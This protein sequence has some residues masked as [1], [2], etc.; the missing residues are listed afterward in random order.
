M[1]ST[2]TLCTWVGVLLATASVTLPAAATPTAPLVLQLP[3]PTGAYPIAVTELHLTDTARADP[4]LSDQPRELMVRLWYPTVDDTADPPTPWMAAGAR[5]EETVYLTN[6]GV[7]PNTWTLGPSHSHTDAPARVDD[8]PFP[9]VLFSP[10]MDDAA[11]WNTAQAEDLASH[12]YVVVDINHTHESFAVQFPDGHTEHTR[13]PLT[14]DTRIMTDELLPPRVADT[15]FVLNALTLLSTHQPITPP[16]DV[17]AG[18]ADI[19]DISRIGMYGHSLGGATTAAAMHDDDRIRA[20][21]DLDGPLLGPVIDDG[22]DRP[23]LM[24]ASQ[25]QPF[26]HRPHWEPSWPNNSG[27][28]LPILIPGTQHESFS[29]Q[30]VILPQ[31]LRAGLQ[32]ATQ[33]QAAIGTIDP[34]H[35][36]EVQRHYLNSF[37]SAAFAGN[38]I[39]AAVSSG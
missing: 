11:G 12:G 16:Q 19:L 32:P 27:L 8:G 4:W 30:Q 3:A 29:D 1:K 15:H 17:P 6:H 20:G 14:R 35:S 24:L 39:S 38:N 23:L 21:V 28:K 36:L 10:G 26:D 2:V 22:L 7:P 37:F 25:F 13:V 18:L 34:I 33:A 9:M 31:L 5:Q